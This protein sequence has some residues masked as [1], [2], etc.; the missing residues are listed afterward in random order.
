VVFRVLVPERDISRHLFPGSCAMLD[1]AEEGGEIVRI[2]PT[3]HDPESDVLL[4][5]DA[6][7]ACL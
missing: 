4:D 7:I 6:T 3:P 5:F 2:S 1:K